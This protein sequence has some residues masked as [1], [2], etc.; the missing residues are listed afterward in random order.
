MIPDV[1]NNYKEELPLN[2]IN[3]LR[4][5]FEDLGFGIREVVEESGVGTYWA[6]LTLIYL[7]VDIFL[8]GGKGNTPELALAS[9]YGEMAETLQCN[10]NGIIRTITGGHTMDLLDVKEFLFSPVEKHITDLEDYFKNNRHFKMLEN[11]DTAKNKIDGIKKITVEN[12][13]TLGYLPLMKYTSYDETEEMY[14]DELLLQQLIT[15]TG[16]AA[17]NAKYEALLQGLC[18]VVERYVKYKV[19]RDDLCLPLIP[20]E[21][22]KQE[23]YAY[24]VY[25]RINSSGRYK[26]E[27]RDASLGGKYPVV[28]AILYDRVKVG[29]T[30]D[31]GCFPVF[32][33]AID[34]TINELLQYYKIDDIHSVLNYST[35]NIDKDICKDMGIE[36]VDAGRFFSSNVR[37]VA[38]Y[39]DSFIGHKYSFEYN[40]W[41]KYELK[42]NKELFIKLCRDIEEVTG[43]KVYYADF[44]F[45]DFHSYRV[46]SP[47]LSI[48]WYFELGGDALLRLES[49]KYVEDYIFRDT[50][51]KEEFIKCYENSEEKYKKVYGNNIFGKTLALYNTHSRHLFLGFAEYVCGNYKRAAVE[52]KKAIINI[53]DKTSVR[54]VLYDCLANYLSLKTHNYNDD[55]ICEIL[56]KMYYKD[57]VDEIRKVLVDEEALKTALFK[58][59][60]SR[61][62]LVDWYETETRAEIF[63]KVQAVKRKNINRTNEN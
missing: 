18:E 62:C 5:K 17:G 57:V 8:S 13:E 27:I 24:G 26:L 61:M 41:Y 35:Y 58:D 55:E 49:R 52:F 44:N 6:K 10:I 37:N 29:Y 60:F 21:V 9:A 2:T 45:L 48:D 39:K 34:R 25:Q 46:Y 12:Y 50:I 40:G 19:F 33:T 15:S 11:L 14:V 22:L 3:N 56:E 32:K 7:G 4:K 42:D 51:S 28:C 63:N 30:V 59:R 16:N 54:S 31:F 23:E 53:N 43:S 38:L 20:E 36:V 47:K 1:K